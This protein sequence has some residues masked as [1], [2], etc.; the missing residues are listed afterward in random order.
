LQGI[1]VGKDKIPVI[2]EMMGQIEKHFGAE[3]M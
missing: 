2:E 3:I 1:I